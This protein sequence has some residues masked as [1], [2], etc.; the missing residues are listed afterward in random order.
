M[1]KPI[2]DLSDSKIFD[3]KKV[4]VS[5]ENLTRREFYNKGKY[6]VYFTLIEEKIPYI[7]L[8][9]IS[10]GEKIIRC[11]PKEWCRLNHA[12]YIAT[13]TGGS[14]FV[15]GVMNFGNAIGKGNTAPSLP[16]VD[17]RWQKPR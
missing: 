12:Y 11:R 2:P 15:E 4:M 8:S 9:G 14:P 16:I 7:R 1:K 5:D 10:P 6:D 3:P 17:A 13:C